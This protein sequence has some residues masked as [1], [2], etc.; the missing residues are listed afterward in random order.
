MD[1]YETPQPETRLDGEN[2]KMPLVPIDLLPV[3]ITKEDSQTLPSVPKPSQ[4]KSAA[5]PSQPPNIRRLKRSASRTLYQALPKSTSP[6]RTVITSRTQHTAN[7]RTEKAEASN[8]VCGQDGAQTTHALTRT[9]RSNYTR[10]FPQDV[11]TP[12]L[13]QNDVTTPSPPERRRGDTAGRTGSSCRLSTAPPFL[14]EP[15]T[16][17]FQTSQL[18]SCPILSSEP[19]PNIPAPKLLTSLVS[20]DTSL[21]T[22]PTMGPTGGSLR[23]ITN[24]SSKLQAYFLTGRPRKTTRQNTHL[25]I[26]KLHYN[27]RSLQDQTIRA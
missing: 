9:T 22:F 1:T 4:I 2:L 3:D 15:P 23:T 6:P 24:I 21:T 25:K 27:I 26:N 12:V 18:F 8:P 14:P 13:C 17:L 20:P 16:F 5:E 7:S 10:P 11:N 19:N